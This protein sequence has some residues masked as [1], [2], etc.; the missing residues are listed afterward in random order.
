MADSNEFL[1]KQSLAERLIELETKVTHQE[2]SLEELNQALCDQQSQLEKLHQ[3]LDLLT[4]K[5]K[6]GLGNDS[7]IRDHEKPP[8]Y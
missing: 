6:Q 3:A 4:H 1:T 2:H 7:N 8:H 5:I